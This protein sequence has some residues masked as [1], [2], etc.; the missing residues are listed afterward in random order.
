VFVMPTLTAK[1]WMYIA[2]ALLVIGV[3]VGYTA[4]VYDKGEDAGLLAG[5]EDCKLRFEELTKALTKARKERDEAA[6][7]LKRKS[8]ERLKF[9]LQDV[10]LVLTQEFKFSH[11][12]LYRPEYDYLAACQFPDSVQEK[13]RE[14]AGRVNAARDRMPGGP[15]AGG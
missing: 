3:F 14:G 11:E 13:F 2:G 6:E 1:M 10:E 8:E 9:R 12:E 15:A 7:K 4:W 5:A